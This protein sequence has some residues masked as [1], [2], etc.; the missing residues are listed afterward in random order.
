MDFA[1]TQLKQLRKAANC[2][3]QVKGLTHDFY[4][5]PAR[6]SPVFVSTA[7]REFSNTGDLVLDPFMGGGTTIVEAM[8]AGRQ[9]VGSDLNE[10]AVFVSKVKTT[11]LTKHEITAVKNWI[12]KTVERMVYDHPRARLERLIDDTRTFNLQLPR[13]VKLRKSI[14]IAMSR[15]RYLPNDK[16][17]S[18]AR[19]I[20]LRTSQWALDNRRSVTSMG[21]FREKMAIIGQQMLDSILKLSSEFREGGIGVRSR[22]LIGCSAGELSKQPFFKNGV[23]KTDLVVTSPPYPGVHVLYHRWQVNGRRE[24]PAPYWISDCNDGKPTSYYTFGNRHAAYDIYL[25]N[26]RSSLAS[27]RQTMKKNGLIIQMVAFSKPRLQ[28]RGYLEVM[29]ETGFSEV[30]TGGKRQNRIWRSVPNR[31][32]HANLKGKTSSSREV[33]LVHEAV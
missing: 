14:A 11:P 29:E 28:L 31:K 24:S 27:I 3:K 1:Q 32:W 22:K 25:E 20:L 4:K 12:P 26:L 19:C 15:L 16:T 17:R 7:I 8:A 6:F 18:F 9:I 23:K 33:V 5:Y 30:S 10:L 21:E 2:K 13:A